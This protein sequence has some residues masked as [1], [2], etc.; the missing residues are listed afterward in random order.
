MN[1]SRTKKKS[2]TLDVFIKIIVTILMLY[3]VFS[4][5]MGQIGIMGKRQELEQLQSEIIVQQTLNIDK[6]RI[7]YTEDTNKYM[8]SIAR[9][10]LGYVLPNEQVY[11][12][13]S[14]K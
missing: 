9:E 3:F 2:S 12:D 13:V 11:V 7:L 10:K 14:G 5:V 8:E 1:K 4:L 6:E